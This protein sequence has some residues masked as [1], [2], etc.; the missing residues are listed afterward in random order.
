VQLSLIVCPCNTPDQDS[1]SMEPCNE[2]EGLEFDSRSGHCIL[3]N[4]SSSAL[5]LGSYLSINRN[6]D[7]ESPGGKGRPARKVDNLTAICEPIA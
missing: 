4:P 3:R 7:Q 6:E 5:A 1:A 2:Q